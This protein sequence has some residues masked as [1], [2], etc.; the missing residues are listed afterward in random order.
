VFEKSAKKHRAPICIAHG[1]PI[2]PL[3]TPTVPLVGPPPKSVLL[4]NDASPSGSSRMN[5]ELPGGLDEARALFESLT[6]GQGV[7]TAITKYSV[8]RIFADDG[9]Q[10]RINADGS[11]RIDLPISID[12]RN[13]ETIRFNSM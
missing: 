6:Q 13:W 3:Q 7:Q 10:L 1:R 8:T 4:G 5:T 2:D 9:T 12:G 11:I